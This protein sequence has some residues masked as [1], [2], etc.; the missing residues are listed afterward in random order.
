MSNNPEQ[1]KNS[2]ENNLESKTSAV[3][4]LNKLSKNQEKSAELSPRDAEAQTEKARQEALKSAVSVEKSGIEKQKS[5]VHSRGPINKKIRDESYSKTMKHVQEDLTTTERAFSKIIHNK[6]VE[7]TS[8]I[9]GNT[10]ARPNAILS[11]AFCAFILTLAV[12][13]VAKTIGYPLSGFETIFAFI[14]GWIIGL[15]YDFFHNLFINNR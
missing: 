15:V 6:V 14:V 11:G 2:I 7:K 9:T 1:F 12:Y 8:E 10:I 4:Q 5:H 3:E 13:I